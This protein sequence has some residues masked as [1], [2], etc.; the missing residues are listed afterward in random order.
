[1]NTNAQGLSLSLKGKV[2]IISG[3]GKENGIGAGIA[4]T[5]AAAG[6][7][8][9]INYVSESTEPRS[10]KVALDI[11]GVAGKGSVVVIRADTSTQEGTE[12]LVHDTLQSFDTDKIDI[13]GMNIWLFPQNK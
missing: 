4:K 3:S 11:E 5:L 13:L 8:V 1:M 2:A 6:A 7:R 12:K 10:K 9:A